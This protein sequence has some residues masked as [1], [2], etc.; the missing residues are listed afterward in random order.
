MPKHYKDEK[1]GSRAY[2]QA[3]KEHNAA[4]KKKK[5]RKRSS[6]SA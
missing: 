1:K 4:M 5:T 2:K 6:Y 3:K